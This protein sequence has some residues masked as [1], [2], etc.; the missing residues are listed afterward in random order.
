M[1]IFQNQKFFEVVPFGWIR[2]VKCILRAGEVPMRIMGT[3]ASFLVWCW[4]S[5][6]GKFGRYKISSQTKTT[7]YIIKFIF[8]IY[9]GF[10]N[11][12]KNMNVKK[13]FFDVFN[14]NIES[15]PKCNNIARVTLHVQQ[16][17]YDY[18]I[19]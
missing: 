1:V 5:R 16:H 14:N 4:T 10:L 2:I 9:H 11:V 15:R 7:Y 6:L 8:H 13:I 12:N 3:S 18:L 17:L 19:L